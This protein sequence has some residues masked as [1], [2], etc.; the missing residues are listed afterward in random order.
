[1]KT[2]SRDDLHRWKAE[3]RDFTLVNVL[4]PEAFAEK[5]IPGSVNVP[6]EDPSF[7]EKVEQAAHGRDR[8]V[9]IY[10]AS[11]ECQASPTA[12]RKLAAAGFPGVYDYEGGMKDWEEAGMPV[13]G[14]AVSRASPD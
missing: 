3:G 10:C 2:L 5:H 13:D 8:P 14:L 9:V 11:L 12:A 7:T 6:G 1:M 4:S